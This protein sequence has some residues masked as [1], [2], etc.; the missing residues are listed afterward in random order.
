MSPRPKI[1]LAFLVANLRSPAVPL[2]PTMTMINATSKPVPADTLHPTPP[3]AHC[4]GQAPNAASNDTNH[5]A[6]LPKL[7]L[8]LKITATTDTVNI[9]SIHRRCVE[10]M[11]LTDPN[12]VLLTNLT[13][14][15]AITDIKEFPVNDQY[16]AAFNIV[17][18]RANKLTL[19]FTVRTNL[20]L[21]A[22]KRKCPL[23]IAHLQSH[24]MSLQTSLL[25]SDHYWHD[26]RHQPGKN[27]P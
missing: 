15:P 14:C 5:L 25:G 27:F 9:A 16:L 23:L 1:V 13:E 8:I 10:L 12:L 18:R 26:P 11:L 19:A 7:R 20:S 6:A 4:N 17:Q 21:N 2:P 24:N 22:I 3:S